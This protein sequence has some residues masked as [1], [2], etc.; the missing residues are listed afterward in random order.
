MQWQYVP[1]WFW[2]AVFAAFG[3]IVGSFLNVCIYRLPRE[4]SIAFPPSHCPKCDAK[5][6]PYD[7]IPI[8][9]YL[10][11]SGKCRHCRE[12]ISAQYPLVEGINSILYL[13][14]FWRFGLGW[15]A[16]IYAIFISAML[17]V[18]FVDYQHMIIP[19]EISLGG[20]PLGIL[21]A[22]TLLPISWIE[23]ILGLLLGSGILLIF[24][25]IWEVVFKIEGMGMGDV[26][27]MA[28]VGSLL[29]WK[30][31]LVTIMVGS[32]A[33]S[34]V[35]IGMAPFSEKGLKTA[36]PYGCFLAPAAVIATFYGNEL[37]AWYVNLIMPG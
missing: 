10:F 18:A 22:A 19:D 24:A 37:I 34:I 3:G 32:L 15:E 1:E 16:I 11:L 8:L 27:L 25:M 7:N 4:E 31:A 23:S 6:A 29:G 17:V 28:L 33:G 9:S 30:L 36:V 13:L 14:T 21:A 26:K 20:I 2:A 12:P 5:I 35:G